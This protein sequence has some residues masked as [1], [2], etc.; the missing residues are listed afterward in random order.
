MPYA[1]YELTRYFTVHLFYQMFLNQMPVMHIST[2][3]IEG[4]PQILL[5]AM[6]ACGAL[7]VKT[8]A[9]GQFIDDTLRS[10]R[11]QLMTE[12]VRSAVFLPDCLS[13]Q[14]FEQAKKSTDTAHHVHLVLAVVLLQTIG[15]FHQ[16]PEQRT[17]SNFYHGMLVTVRLIMTSPG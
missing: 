13:A 12:F 14:R 1:I 17:H 2:F 11:E 8:T 10:S 5:S 15:L 6:Q 7:Y 4:K 3:T 16:R 9:A